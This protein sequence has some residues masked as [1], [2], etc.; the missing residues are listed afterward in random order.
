M[1]YTSLP[2]IPMP[3]FVSDEKDDGTFDYVTLKP[4]INSTKPEFS[5]YI[6]SFKEYAEK[7]CDCTLTQGCG[8]I[9]LLYDASLRKG[10]YRIEITEKAQSYM[11]VTMTELHMHFRQFFNL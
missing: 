8:G 6:E 11:P 5:T 2:V 7:L 3:K 9:E 1:K 4:H 10:G